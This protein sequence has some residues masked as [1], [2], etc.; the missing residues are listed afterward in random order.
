MI[1][2]HKTEKLWRSAAFFFIIQNAAAQSLT[3]EAH[4][5]ATDLTGGYQV[6]AS[7]LNH[8]GKLDLIALASNMTDLVWFENP[9]WQRHVMATNLSHMINL[10]AW[11]VDG[12]G[13]PEIAL[14]YGFSMN[15]AQSTG[16]VAILHHDGDP[17][18]IWTIKP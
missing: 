6:V 4:T 14:A 9:S 13:I 17:R 10:A 2:L 8:D 11:D 3:F 1:A 16:N 12:D 15:A 18:R 7:D 5:L